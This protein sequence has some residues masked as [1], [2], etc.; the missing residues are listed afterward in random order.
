MNLFGGN[1]AA[2]LGN[3]GYRC[4]LDGNKML[5][6]GKYDEARKKHEEALACYEQAYEQGLDRIHILMAYGIL[7][8]RNGQ[9]EKAKEVFLKIHYT[10]QLAPDNR[11]QLRINYSV[12]LWRL[13]KL[14][15]A[16][17]TIQ[18]AA[19]DARTT[20]IYTTLGMY[21]I[22]R[23][24]KTGD[25]TEAIAFN[26]EAYEYDDEDAAILDNIGLMHLRMSEKAKQDG[27]ATRAEQ[28]RKLAYDFFSRAHKRKPGQVTTLYYL[29]E[30]F[31][32]D[33]NHDKA[34]QS[35]DAALTHNFSGVSPVS[36]QMAEALKARIG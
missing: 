11:F 32:E 35:I 8:M 6:I 17:S 27:D 3:K 16:I 20:V 12:C 26:N 21:L 10:P 36:R 33:G 14:D 7:L 5:D 23:A 18:R 28:E 9:Y 4:H 31:Y 15:E 25:F 1:A 19:E 2:K 29:A 13:G 34:R 22:F 30:M 24:E